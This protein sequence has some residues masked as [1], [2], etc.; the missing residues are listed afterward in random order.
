MFIIVES[1]GVKMIKRILCLFVII[2]QFFNI[3]YAITFSRTGNVERAINSCSYQYGFNKNEFKALT[4]VL[5]QNK[6]NLSGVL[7]SQIGY[8][9]GMSAE[10]FVTSLAYLVDTVGIQEII[11]NLEPVKSEGITGQGYYYKELK[12]LKTQV[13]Q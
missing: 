9:Q 2:F 8:Y 3:S 7:N 12:R 5:L 11:K 13:R 10:S 4:N 6:V 1:T